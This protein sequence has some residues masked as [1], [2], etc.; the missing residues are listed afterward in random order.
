M[1][2]RYHLVTFGKTVKDITR[3]QQPLGGVSDSGRRLQTD[4]ASMGDE[5]V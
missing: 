3:S 2:H 5:R 4:S 1:T